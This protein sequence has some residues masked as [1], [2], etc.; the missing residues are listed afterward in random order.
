MPS[1][2]FVIFLSCFAFVPTTFGSKLVAQDTVSSGGEKETLNV[3]FIGNSYTARH[4]LAEVV[5]AM[6]ESG[7]PGLTLNV[8]SVIYGG[9]RLVD[10]WRLGTQNI[11]KLHSLTR[12]DQQA[13]I[14]SLEKTLREDPKDGYAKS[15]LARHQT[16][17][18]D[19][20]SQRK[21]WDV[22]VLQSYRDDLEGEDSLYAKYAPKF[23]E[24]AKRREHA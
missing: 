23:A 19:L 2:R 5:K 4:N 20:E 21:T 17:L 8:S 24:L 16:L 11:V 12:S 22:I 9:R 13:T 14:A 3:L 15:A 10:H 7:N 18:R 1:I 6:A